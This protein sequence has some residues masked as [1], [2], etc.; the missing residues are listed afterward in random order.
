MHAALYIDTSLLQVMVA[1]M[2]RGDI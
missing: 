2:T 1:E